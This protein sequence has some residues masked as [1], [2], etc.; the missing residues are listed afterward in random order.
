MKKTFLLSSFTLIIITDLFCQYDPTYNKKYWFYRNRFV[1]Y[2]TVVG[3][4]IGESNVADRRNGKESDKN[5]SGS[6]QIM[7]GDQGT[8]IGDYIAMLATEYKLLKLAGQDV[9]QTAK[10][11]YY[12]LFAVNRLD[13]VAE[14]YF[15]LPAELNGFFIRNDIPKVTTDFISAHP[16]VNKE[17]SL[18]QT[19]YIPG[20]GMPQLVT[21]AVSGFDPSPQFYSVCKEQ[22]DERG[23]NLMSP[24]QVIGLYFGMAMVAKLLPPDANFKG[25]KF[26]DNNVNFVEA[27]KAI[28]DRITMWMK[29][30]DWK[31]VSPTGCVLYNETSFVRYSY[32][33]AAGFI[34]GKSD[35][36][37]DV[38]T[39]AVAWCSVADL[40]F[41]ADICNSLGNIFGNVPGPCDKEYNWKIALLLAAIGDS[42]DECLLFDFTNSF[43]FSHS[44]LF[45]WQS[46]YCSIFNVL[47]PSIRLVSSS[48]L[49]EILS[50][51]PCDGPFNHD[52]N[53]GHPSDY[54]PGWSCPFRFRGTID[55]QNGGGTWSRGNFHGLDYMILHN[56]Y[57][58]L[59]GSQ[60]SKGFP[61]PQY[62]TNWLDYNS[63]YNINTNSFD[64]STVISGNHISETPGIFDFPFIWPYS[65]FPP[66]DNCINC[67]SNST[68]GSMDH[69][70]EIRALN[71]I[72]ASNK[73][74]AVTG[75][76][77]ATGKVSY[78]A[79]ESIVLEPGFEVEAGADFEAYIEPVYCSGGAYA[80]QG[81][82]TSTKDKLG[83]QSINDST[84]LV[85]S[86]PLQQNSNKSKLVP[87]QNQRITEGRFKSKTETK[88]KSDNSQ[89]QISIIPNPSASGTFQLHFSGSENIQTNIFVYNLLG[90]T[91]FASI[92]QPDKTAKSEI[93]I[94]DRAKG[95]YFVKIQ[96]G[97]KVIMQKIVYQ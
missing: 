12:A 22:V 77:D 51:A 30:N 43:I 23:S 79:G 33:R 3:D 59:S 38:S 50:T 7:H 40:L 36:Y 35:K 90:E 67:E 11:L 91:V 1:D 46:Y 66:P 28:T 80:K 68:L 69:P 70:I 48:T 34:M 24:D 6:Q 4:G 63:T 75:N 19:D 52:P 72:S 45:N 89:S 73:I 61:L 96:N 78:R 53:P 81:N 37:L 54:A 20:S 97:E 32:A 74:K 16:E 47:H 9:D 57:Y 13:E 27:A 31:I 21:D 64:Y 60:D 94:S 2:F 26:Q 84:I 41:G 56:L 44:S 39:T 62:N 10:E 92:I 42:W 8:N 55:E 17:L 95:V 83:D 29:N 65:P 5:Y 18:Q 87:E 88:E 25:K 82:P 71:T 14:T 86:L 85:S 93:N 49:E 58:L 76:S 15:N